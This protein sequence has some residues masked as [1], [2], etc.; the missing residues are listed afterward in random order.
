MV[1]M[2][3]IDFAIRCTEEP[4]GVPCDICD[5]Y[6]EMQKLAIEAFIQ[7]TVNLDVN[8]SIMGSKALHFP[9]LLT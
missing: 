5:P 2:D 7:V 9:H 6:S 4:H 1:C 8:V 3:G